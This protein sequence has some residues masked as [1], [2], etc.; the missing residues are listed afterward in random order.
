M[1]AR[2]RVRGRRN[3]DGD[4]CGEVISL[5]GCGGNKMQKNGNNLANYLQIWIF[6]CTFAVAKVA[7]L[8]I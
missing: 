6:F 5:N 3:E 1:S 4:R 8:S 7:P 2:W